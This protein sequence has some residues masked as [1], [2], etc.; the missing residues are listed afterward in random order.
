[1]G[2]KRAF[3]GNIICE[4]HPGLYHTKRRS[5]LVQ[6]PEMLQF[7]VSSLGILNLAWLCN[8]KCPSSVKSK[9][10]QLEVGLPIPSRA[11]YCLCLKLPHQGSSWVAAGTWL[12]EFSWVCFLMCWDPQEKRNALLL[13]CLHK[14]FSFQQIL[15]RN[16]IVHNPF[17]FSDPLKKIDPMIY[18]KVKYTSVYESKVIYESL[19]EVISKQHQQVERFLCCSPKSRVARFSK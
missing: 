17:I 5:H 9:P 11:F 13:P 8:D 12:E 7:K 19:F 10:H 2:N 6:A 14:S 16:Q 1:M 15:E 3:R 18:Q 4:L